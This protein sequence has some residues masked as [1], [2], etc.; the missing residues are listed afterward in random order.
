MIKLPS[1]PR[2]KR[3]APSMPGIADL[4]A[5]IRSTLEK[6]KLDPA[7]LA[8]RRIAVTVGSR[9]IASLQPTIRTLC[10]WLKEKGAQPFVIPAMGS[11]G[12]ATDEGQRQVLEDYGITEASMGVPV[13]SSMKT[14]EIG[15]TP[16]GFKVHMD[17]LAHEADGVFVFNRIKPPHQ[18]QRRH[19][20]RLAEGHDG[21]NGEGKREPSSCIEA[22]SARATNP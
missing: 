3:V 15:T 2:L 17:R 13:R 10:D 6:A 5:E 14:A 8:K 12:G 11:H 18:L 20:E 16:E 4:P 9:G 22:R 19:R 1:L 21:R 7:R